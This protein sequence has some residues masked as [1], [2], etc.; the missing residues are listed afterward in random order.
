MPPP[1]EG[2]GSPFAWGDADHLDELLGEDFDL[3]LET[4]DCPQPGESA[5]EVWDLF[6]S[7]YG[8]TKS[9]AGSLDDERRDGLRRDWVAYFD[10]YRNGSGVVQPRPYVLVL[11]SRR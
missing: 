2:V 7:S 11:G 5:E 9:L 8:P 4:G 6:M 1:P 3:R 10:Q